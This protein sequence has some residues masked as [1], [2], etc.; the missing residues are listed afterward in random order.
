MKTVKSCL[1]FFWYSFIFFSLHHPSPW[2]HLLAKWSIKKFLMWSLAYGVSTFI[3]TCT[4]S[5]HLFTYSS[6][7]AGSCFTLPVLWCI[8]IHL[9]AH[10]SSLIL[11]SSPLWSPHSE[12]GTH[13]VSVSPLPHSHTQPTRISNLVPS[14]QIRNLFLSSINQVLASFW[15]P[16]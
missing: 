1:S 6:K 7:L 12:M 16:D 8:H 4:A 11:H 13:P 2:P 5:C 9:L 10:L 15:D 14:L 3:P